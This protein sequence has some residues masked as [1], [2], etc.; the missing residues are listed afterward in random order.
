MTA[1]HDRLRYVARLTRAAEIMAE[2]VLSN[3]I[4]TPIF[5]RIDAELEAETNSGSA[6][7]RARHL[8]RVS[9]MA[10]A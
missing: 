5:E 9:K 6:L 10:A 2:L 4:Y 7:D 1:S 8:V 3:P